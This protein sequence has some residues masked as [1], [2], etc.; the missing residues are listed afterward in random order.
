MSIIATNQGGSFEILP[1]GS[2][3]ARCYSMVHIGTITEN[4]MGTIK[5]LNKVRITW[6]LP[7][8]LK[9]FNEEKGEQPYVVSK[10]F[11]LSMNEKSNLRKFLESWR[12]KNF[13]EAEAEKFDITA[14]LDKAC[15]LSIIHKTA[16]NGNTYA[17][18]SGVFALPK[19]YQ[20]PERINKITE[21]NYEHFDQELFD[22]LPQ[23]LKDKIVMSKE[24]Q[25]MINPHEV[26]TQNWLESSTPQNEIEDDLPF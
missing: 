13:T 11:T 26:N 20:M 25:K 22:S 14:L 23:F 10:E 19:G 1:A 21:L 3:P 9:V 8:E 15:Q 7:T 16:K 2:Y 18:I 17:E 5:D 24:Y 4:I 12:G 6:E